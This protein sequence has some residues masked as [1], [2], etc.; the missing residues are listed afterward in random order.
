MKGDVADAKVEVLEDIDVDL[1]KGELVF[2]HDRSQQLITNL[3]LLLLHLPVPNSPL[4]SG[5]KKQPS[6][7]HFSWAFIEQF[8]AVLK[9]MLPCGQVSALSAAS[10]EDVIVF[11]SFL[12]RLISVTGA[13]H[14]DDPSAFFRGLHTVGITASADDGPSNISALI[15]ASQGLLIS[16]S[17]KEVSD[18]LLLRLLDASARL[19]E[20]LDGRIDHGGWMSLALWRRDG[21][22]KE[23]RSAVNIATSP[24]YLDRLLS[25]LT[26]PV[27]RPESRITA[28]KCIHRIMKATHWRKGC[29]TIESFSEEYSCALSARYAPSLDVSDKA[30]SGLLMMAV[31]DTSCDRDRRTITEMIVTLSEVES[32]WNRLISLL[33]DR[34]DSL[35]HDIKSHVLQISQIAET[36]IFNMSRSTLFPL[37]H[38][39]A[40]NNEK[41]LLRVLELVAAAT[42]ANIAALTEKEKEKEG[43][44]LQRY[45]EAVYRATHRVAD[46]DLWGDLDTCMDKI[47]LLEER[48]SN[49]TLP[50]HSGEVPLK[51][52][53]ALPSKGT[54]PAVSIQEMLRKPTYILS[55]LATRMVPLLECYFRSVCQDLHYS[56]TH[57]HRASLLHHQES[58]SSLSEV[59]DI[60]HSLSTH[61]P[62]H[63]AKDL[64]R[65]LSVPPL[66]RFGSPS[67]QS[68]DAPQTPISFSSPLP[69]SSCSYSRVLA[70]TSSF[71][72]FSAAR[73]DRDYLQSSLDNDFNAA[74]VAAASAEKLT[75]FCE[76]N[77]ALLN[78]LVRQNIR[79]LESSLMPLLALPG[80]RKILDFDV[81]RTYLKLRLKRLKRAIHSDEDEN[82]EEDED[83][84]DDDMTIALE[85]DRERIIE[86]SYEA[87]QDVSVRHLIRGK[88]DIMFEDEDGVDGGGLTREWYAL[89]M[90]EV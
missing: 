5:P 7:R 66:F 54:S 42:T 48:S 12:H 73:R 87:F 78:A 28:L 41:R 68:H 39:P 25:L 8:D 72:L 58:S 65:A 20:H 33:G 59:T 64:L 3:L 10:F 38:L 21:P 60:D 34:A 55:P 75:L 85:V 35:I 19:F 2:V 17:S 4:K 67:P 14:S 50:Q 24:T 76:K 37:P 11:D 84:E 80:C 16:E 15:V 9:G 46:S 45:H 51:G 74:A 57:L 23:E 47:R 30:I 81:K 88:L 40:A 13:L 82:E 1:E 63:T 36:E 18:V 56:G 69:F 31:E 49:R 53:A 44:S 90:R 77:R 27:L 62:K 89:L 43:S 83:E 22:E 86:C 79:L 61:E 71:S 6:L 29:L 32:N 26:H 52:A 70:P